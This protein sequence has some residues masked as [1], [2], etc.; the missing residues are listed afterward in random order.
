MHG[1]KLRNGQRSDYGTTFGGQAELYD[2]VRPGYPHEVVTALCS[3]AAGPVC[4]LGAGTGKLGAA[5]DV[6]LA[7]TPWSVLAVDPDEQLLERNPCRTRVGTAEAVPVEDATISLTIAAQSWHWF[8]QPAAG[9][10]IARITGMGGHLA[11]VN[12]QLD[13]RVSWVH[14]LSRIM[15][16]G[17]VYRPA[18]R[19]E[20]PGEFGPVRAHTVSFTTPVGVAEVIGLARTRTYWLRSN[21][22]TRARVEDNIR[23]YLMGEACEDPE[24]LAARTENGRFEL[25]YMCLVYIA[26]RC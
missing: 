6:A 12:N 4:D 24:F 20:L 23:Q 22:A 10:E 19:P 15:H 11:I 17:D 14:R 7:D 18:W 3:L 25:P 21:E 2:R 26:P 9:V 8:A 13:V 16:A 1:P 5:L